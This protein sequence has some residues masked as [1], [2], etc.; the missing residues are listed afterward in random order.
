MFGNMKAAN[1]KVV[2]PRVRAW[3][4][5]GLDCLCGNVRMASRAL[6]SIYDR[7]LAP[8]GLTSNQLA[9]L[10][11]V[12]AREPVA[13]GEIA[14]VLAMDKTTASRNLAALARSGL[15]ASRPG[16]DARVKLVSSTA[17]GRKAFAAALPKWKLAQA[18][19]EDRMGR[20]SFA[21]TVDQALRIAQAVAPHEA[22]SR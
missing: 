16:T 8:T 2:S 11:C 14:S 17:K 21:R 15:V 22:R 6:T 12:V 1:P 5:R 13:L 10:W 19:V 3:R 7:F 20:T 9:V 18:W 4:G